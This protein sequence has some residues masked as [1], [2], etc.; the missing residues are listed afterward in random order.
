MRKRRG[1]T[2]VELAIV[3]AILGILAMYAIPKYQGMVEEART[4]QAKAQLGTVRSALAIYYAKYSGKFPSSL[5]GTIFAEGRV[6][7][8]EATKADGTIVESNGVVNISGNGTVDATEITDVGGWVY[9]VTADLTQADVR[10]NAK[11]TSS[12][13]K[14]WYEY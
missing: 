8:V 1:F 9:D 12:E 10:I 3:I 11:G 2:L 4:A 5:D 7:T 6:P 13:G 14:Y